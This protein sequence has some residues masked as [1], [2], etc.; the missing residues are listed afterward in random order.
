MIDVKKTFETAKV[1]SKKSRN[2]LY[3]NIYKIQR[4]IEKMM[5]LMEGKK[6]GK[7]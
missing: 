4:N 6:E 2:S 5:E 7:I 3:K 1:H